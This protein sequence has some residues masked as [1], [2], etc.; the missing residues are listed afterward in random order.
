MED[1]RSASMAREQFTL[2]LVA[3]FAALALVL[4]AVGLYGVT[5]FAVAQ[6]TR[7]LGIR[8]ALG[9]RPFDVVRLVLGLG[10]RLVFSGLALDTAASLGLSQLMSS[11]LFGTSAR[12]PIP[13]AG[14]GL[15]L[16]SVSLL[17]CYI[18][19]RR[20]MRVDPVVALRV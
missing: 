7:E 13:F 16:A 18:P 11:M 6:R 15:L 5:A 3:L 17:A 1:V 2:L 14:V 8:V 10:G 12:D 19:A 9:A 4:A 20:A